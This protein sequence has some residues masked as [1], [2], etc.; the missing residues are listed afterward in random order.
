[1]A[2]LFPKSPR[3]YAF[4]GEELV[5]EAQREHGMRI[6]VYS[7]RVADGKMTQAEADK[8]IAQQM[9]IIKILQAHALGKTFKEPA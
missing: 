3:E 7:R 4:T 9:A 6:D 1:M 8:R 2:D 5:L